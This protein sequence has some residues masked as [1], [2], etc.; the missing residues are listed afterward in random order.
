VMAGAAP[1]GAAGAV[2]AQPAMVTIPLAFAAMVGASVATRSRRPLHL[3]R[4][5]VRLHTPETVEVDRGA[6]QPRGALD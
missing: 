5:M 3:A 1:A 2:L 4:V 6:F